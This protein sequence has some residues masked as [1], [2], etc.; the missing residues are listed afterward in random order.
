MSNASLRRIADDAQSLPVWSPDGRYIAFLRR[1][2]DCENNCRYRIV[3]VPSTGGEEHKVGPELAEPSD[4]A[5]WGGLAWLRGPVPTTPSSSVADP[6]ELQRCVD[7]W[8]RAKMSPRVGGLANV[9]LVEGRCQVTLNYYG[10]ICPQMPEMPFR[11]DCPSHGAGLHMIDPRFRV[12]NA[13][14][15]RDGKLGL[16]DTPRGPNLSLPKAPP[17]PLLDGYVVPF[18]K[19][20]APLAELHNTRTV[21]GSCDDE[22]RRYPVRCF[23]GHF[24]HNSCFKQPGRLQVGDFALCPDYWRSADPMSYLRVLISRDQN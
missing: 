22:E 12:W 18:G 1:Q 8:N 15:D 13:Q 14:V 24:L 9:S 2:G 6:L 17:Y 4:D 3:V 21:S 16:V 23:W 11:Y 19:D 7:I 5:E 10:G 20:G